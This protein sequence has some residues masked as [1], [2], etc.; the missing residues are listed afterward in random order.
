M[1]PFVKTK[2]TIPGTAL[3]TQ[4]HLSKFHT[5]HLSMTFILQE[6]CITAL[7]D[8]TVIVWL[9]STLEKMQMS[10]N[11]S[12]HAGTST[13]DHAEHLNSRYA[14]QDGGLHAGISALITACK[15]SLQAG[16]KH[17]QGIIGNPR[18]VLNNI[19][20]NAIFVIYP[21]ISILMYNNALHSLSSQRI[22]PF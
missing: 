16:K 12:R 7:S 4:F 3:V 11:G 8:N 9:D 19:Q 20:I 21:Q 18:I 17:Q 22:D 10:E 5:R 6:P 14:G 2:Q 1:Y 15:Q 13:P